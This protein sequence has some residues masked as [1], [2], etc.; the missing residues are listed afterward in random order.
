MTRTYKVI[1]MFM[2]SRP[3]QTLKSGLT[4]AK[5]QEHCRDKE[6]S[7]STATEPSNIAYTE[8]HGKW[9]DGYEQE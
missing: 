5:A 6:T 9:F 3:A 8:A 4:L 1:R 7:S 2:D